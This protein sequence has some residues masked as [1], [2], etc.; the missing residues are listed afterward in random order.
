M[1]AVAGD[2]QFALSGVQGVRT[3]GI[4]VEVNDELSLLR[5]ASRKRRML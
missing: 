5:P 2:G 4:C 1:D 3:N